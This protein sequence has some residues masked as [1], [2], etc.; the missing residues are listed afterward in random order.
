[1]FGTMM[2]GGLVSVMALDALMSCLY[3]AERSL[4]RS[5]QAESAGQDGEH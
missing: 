3:R 5:R 4:R 2:L 1:M